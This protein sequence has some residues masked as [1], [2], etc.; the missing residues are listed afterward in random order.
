MPIG[1]I[2]SDLIGGAGKDILQ[3]ANTLIDGVTYSKEEREQAK[4]D[5]AKM[6]NEHIARLTELANDIEAKYLEDVASARELQKVALE[7]NDTF[8]KRFLYYFIIGWS[9]FSMAFLVG[10]TFFPIPAESV[11]FADT[12]LGFLLGTAIASVF[13][14][15]VGSSK[16]SRNKDEA[17]VNI[18]KSLPRS[19]N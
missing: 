4:L 12:I 6:T 10:V 17:I 14:F 9:L 8:S 16:G 11:R 18:S 1:K 15:M 13:S 5:F 2:F 19:E 7:Q 3:G